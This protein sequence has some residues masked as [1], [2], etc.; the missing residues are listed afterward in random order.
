MTIYL[1]GER[2]TK[3]SIALLTLTN[4]LNELRLTCFAL[5]FGQLLF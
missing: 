1:L 2:V 5:H 4:D 3:I